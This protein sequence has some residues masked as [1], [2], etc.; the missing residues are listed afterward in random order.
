LAESVKR[1]LRFE[2]V[3]H[4]SHQRFPVGFDVVIEAW[5]LAMHVARAALQHCVI[6]VGF[7]D[8]VRLRLQ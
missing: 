6:F 1:E 2:G 4:G 8:G 5:K 3:W 7:V